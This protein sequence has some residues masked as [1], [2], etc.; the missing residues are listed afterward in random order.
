MN[1]KKVLNQLKDVFSPKEVQLSEVE[2]REEEL[3]E[4]V[5]EKT[6][7]AEEPM[8]EEEPKEEKE[9]VPQVEY[10]TK[11]E[12]EEMKRTF[13]EMFAAI[14]K[15]KESKQEV[16]QELSKDEEVEVELSEEADEI[17][18]SPEVEVEKKFDLYKP[19]STKDESIKSRIYSKLFN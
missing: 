2:V 3:V 15:E 19:Q 17:P 6:E 14:Q 5:V 11:V 7:L 8:E 16:P 13:M 18:H 1:T 10:V 9:A 12:L 4:E